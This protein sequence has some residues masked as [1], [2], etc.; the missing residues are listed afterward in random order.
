MKKLKVQKVDLEN[1]LKDSGS[2][3]SSGRTQSTITLFA[4]ALKG[5]TNLL[6]AKRKWLV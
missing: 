4:E 6:G 2:T 5:D 3:S 1:Y